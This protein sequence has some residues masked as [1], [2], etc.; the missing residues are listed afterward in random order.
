M[1][2]LACNIV[3]NDYEATRK[4]HMG[5]V[6]LCNKCY[7]PSA[8]NFGDEGSI[9]VIEEEDYVNESLTPLEE[10]LDPYFNINE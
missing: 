7:S 6:D 1:R 5:F 2:C 3:L 4:D 8:E 9:P 10:Y